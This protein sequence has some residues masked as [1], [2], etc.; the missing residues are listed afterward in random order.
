MMKQKLIALAPYLAVLAADFYLLPLLMV[1]TGS[2]MLLMLVVMPV[3]GFVTGV[4]CGA[5]RGFEPLLALIALILYLPTLPRYYNWTAWPYA[6]AYFLILPAGMAVG[7][8][9]LKKR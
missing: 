1:D 6:V 5:L 8:L 7:R 3:I 2:A 9:S 4:L